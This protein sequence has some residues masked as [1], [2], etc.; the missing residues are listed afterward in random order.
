MEEERLTEEVLE[1]EAPA[2]EDAATPQSAAEPPTAPLERGAEENGGLDPAR[3]ESFLRFARA[4]P[5]VRADDI[6]DEVWIDVI[7]GADLTEAYVRAE[8]RRLTAEAD[9][10]RRE[11]DSLAREIRAAARSAGSRAS[12]GAPR[13]ADPFDAGW[14]G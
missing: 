1:T 8:N 2:A 10:L 14:E 5:D 12:A 7:G 11:R 13:A 9:E 4:Y 6:P 3:R